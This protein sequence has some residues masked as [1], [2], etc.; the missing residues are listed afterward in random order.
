MAS[1]K[2]LPDVEWAKKC[3]KKK[4]CFLHRSYIYSEMHFH[5][6]ISVFG[7]ENENLLEMLKLVEKQCLTN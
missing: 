2:P 7:N 3:K 1:V 6:K 5:K 4:C